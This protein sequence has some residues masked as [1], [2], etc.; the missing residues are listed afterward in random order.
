MSVSVEC[1]KLLAPAA[2]RCREV[3]LID[4]TVD[5]I[6]TIAAC[7]PSVHELELILQDSTDPEPHLK[8]LEQL[9]SLR[10]VDIFCPR[11]SGDEQLGT[12]EGH[13]GHAS[14]S[15]DLGSAAI[16]DYLMERRSF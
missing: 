2:R 9:T 1:M 16:K 12:T 15:I 10:H 6:A 11:V 4:S 3:G 8:P 7:F 5:Q 13:I 14:Y